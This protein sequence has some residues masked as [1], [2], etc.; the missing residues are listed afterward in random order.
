VEF[1]TGKHPGLAGDGFAFWYTTEKEMEGPVFGNKNGFNGLG[2]F[3]D[4]YMNTKQVVWNPF[5]ILIE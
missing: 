5:G 1:K 2:I 3:F 4:S